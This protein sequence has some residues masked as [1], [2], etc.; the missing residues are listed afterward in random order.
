VTVFL[1]WGAFALLAIAALVYS[2]RVNER[3]PTIAARLEANKQATRAAPVPVAPSRAALEPADRPECA[4][5]VAAA[6]AGASAGERG[7]PLDR[8]L[9]QGSIAWQEDPAL[10]SAL[11]AAATDAYQ[12]TSR[13]AA[14]AAAAACDQYLRAPADD[15]GPDQ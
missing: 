10:K 12:Q 13:G 15:A 14:E 1:R 11:T 8:V 9:R 7:E 2:Y 4:P 3:A 5:F 6:S